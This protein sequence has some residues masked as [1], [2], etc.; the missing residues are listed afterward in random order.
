MPKKTG[1]KPHGGF[2]IYPRHSHSSCTTPR[3]SH[4]HRSLRS[5]PIGHGGGGTY[6]SAG[7]AP[8]RR[9][10]PS[11]GPRAAAPRLRRP[12]RRTRP[13][14][15]SRHHPSKP[16]TPL[17]SPRRAPR[18]RPR[19]HLP[20]PLPPGPAPGPREHQGLRP[21]TV[22]HLHPRFRQA[23]RAHP[24]VG[25]GAARSRRRRRGR[26]LLRMDSA[27]G[28]RDRRRGDRILAVRRPRHRRHALDLP[29]P[30]Q[31]A[32]GQRRWVHRRVPCDSRR[33]VVP[34][35]RALDDVR[36]LHTWPADWKS[37]S[38]SR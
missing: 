18:R 25:Q 10:L 7:A 17:P 36:E 4:R 28:P 20:V 35:E 33:A 1:C 2:G 14:S 26:L 8:A 29:P 24:R 11:A 9:P 31:A 6:P 34:V 23:A 22:P 12:P 5:Q 15:L 32:C 27:A 30:G 19:R 13:P 21:G 3:L 16:P 38:A 37:R